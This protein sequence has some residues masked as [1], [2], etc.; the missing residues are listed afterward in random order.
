[1]RNLQD[2]CR[3]EQLQPQIREHGCLRLLPTLSRLA[4]VTGGHTCADCVLLALKWKQ[5]TKGQTKEA[6][7]FSSSLCLGQQ[8]LPA[9]VLA[10]AR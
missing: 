3:Q 4:Y 10:S 5:E 1:M 9:V 8:L 7:L 2:G 6:I